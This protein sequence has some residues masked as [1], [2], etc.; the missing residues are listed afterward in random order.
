MI[1]GLSGERPVNWPPVVVVGGGDGW[2]WCVCV[3][4]CG[5]ECGRRL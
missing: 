1:A 2:W 5:G 4:V 3:V